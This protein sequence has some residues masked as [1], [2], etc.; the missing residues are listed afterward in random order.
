MTPAVGD[1]LK[2][3]LA[4]S[5]WYDNRC[6]GACGIIYHDRDNA[7]A[8]ALLSKHAGPHMLQITRHV[9]FVLDT[10]NVRRLTMDVVHGHDIG[11][12]WAKALGFKVSDPNKRAIFPAGAY[13]TEYERI[14]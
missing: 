4:I 7:E 11:H 6:M 9:R 1:V 5:G 12:R 2:S 13:V 10:Q 8:W 14:R 3:T